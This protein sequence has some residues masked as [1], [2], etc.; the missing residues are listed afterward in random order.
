MEFISGPKL[1][2]EHIVVRVGKDGSSVVSGE[3]PPAVRQRRAQL[4][5]RGGS[6]GSWLSDRAG[7]ADYRTTAPVLGTTAQVFRYG[8]GHPGD[9]DFT[10]LWTEG[11]RVLEFRAPVPDLASFERHLAALRQVD[12]ET[13]LGALPAD[14]VKA[15]DRGHTVTGMLRGIPLPTGFKPSQIPDGGLTTNRYQVGADV[16]GVVA[17]RWFAQWGDDLQQGDARGVA[18]AERALAGAKRWPILREMEREGAYPQVLEEYA[19][20]MPSRE[21]FGRSLLPEVD[22]GLGCAGKG[23]QLP[24]GRSGGVAGE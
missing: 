15:A 2:P 20:A 9:Y 4:N 8:E 14:V 17:C 1:P 5:W 11:G 3:R 6:I 12:T 19:A 16:T 18:E 24:T 7:S 23:V 21:W 13:W 10:A 22:S